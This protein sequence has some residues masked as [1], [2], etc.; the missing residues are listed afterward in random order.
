MDRKPQ[1]GGEELAPGVKAVDHPLADY[2]LQLIL[3]TP[4]RRYGASLRTMR[5]ISRVPL[6]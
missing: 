1:G 2:A 4:T 6:V 5:A 3:D